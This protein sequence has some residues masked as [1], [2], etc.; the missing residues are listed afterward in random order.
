MIHECPRC[1]YSTNVKSNFIK[2]LVQRQI[3][4]PST[5]ADVSLESII[6]EYT[7]QIAKVYKCESCEKGFNSRSGLAYHRKH[8]CNSENQRLANIESGL[9]NLAEQLAEHTNKSDTRDKGNNN[10]NTNNV[11]INNGTINNVN[12]NIEIKPFGEETT[13]HI[14]REIAIKC[15]KRGV[16][17][18]IDMLDMIY[19]NSE[20][21]EN[22]NVKLKSLKNKLVEVFKD[23]NW[24]TRDFS[25]AVDRMISVS[26]SHVMNQV[27]YKEVAE[28]IDLLQ[29]ANSMMSLPPKNVKGIHNHAK[30][31]LVNRRDT[32]CD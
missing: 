26:R 9:K 32:A 13:D 2:H 29:I 8:H 6:V 10:V 28:N 7:E 15:F 23:S 22:H 31:R 3:P 18:L 17:G 5:K 25:T 27:D 1:G 16:Y 20:V 11:G 19:F 30:A 21:P 12:I 14:S 4:C 24:E